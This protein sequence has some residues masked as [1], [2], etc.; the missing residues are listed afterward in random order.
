M[1]KET[2]K[3][4]IVEYVNRYYSREKFFDN[5]RFEV[6]STFFDQRQ[7][8][9]YVHV[10]LGYV[11]EPHHSFVRKP[12]GTVKDYIIMPLVKGITEE[13]INDWFVE[14]GLVFTGF[15]EDGDKKFWHVEW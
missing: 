2:I 11:M 8:I 14:N 7:D 15:S 6:K 12:L 10:E 1:E 3:E 4:E 9:H 5:L 13:D